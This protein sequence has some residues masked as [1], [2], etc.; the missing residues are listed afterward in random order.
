PIPVIVR[1]NESK[2]IHVNKAFTDFYLSTEELVL[3]KKTSEYRNEFLERD[4]F[5]NSEMEFF[6]II[7]NRESVYKEKTLIRNG[8]KLILNEWSVPYCYDGNISGVITG[9]IDMTEIN[10]LNSQLIISRDEALKANRDKSNFIAVMS[11]EIRTPLNAII[12]SLEVALIDNE[13]KYL[14]EAYTASLD[15]MYILK[16]ILDISKVEFISSNLN[17]EC[18][19]VKSLIE[20]V[21]YIF[22]PLSIS[23]GIDFVI[24][25][26]IGDD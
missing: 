6:E 21:S 13:N 1:D 12:G 9:W 24:D 7:K 25:I 16:S 18:V 11:H 22:K 14:N 8:E 26:S 20:S 15:L 4:F 10:Y 17:I 5:I 19:K 2:L 23:R 3:G